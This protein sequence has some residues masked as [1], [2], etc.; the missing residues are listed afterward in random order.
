MRRLEVEYLPLRCCLDASMTSFMTCIPV[1]WA[2]IGEREVRNPTLKVEGTSGRAV[3][4][5]RAQGLSR[6]GVLRFRRP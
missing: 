5:I 6:S 1:L 3:K 4:L 2:M